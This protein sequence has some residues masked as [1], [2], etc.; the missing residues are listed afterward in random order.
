VSIPSQ[1]LYGYPIDRYECTPSQLSFVF[2]ALV[3]GEALTFA[4][5]LTSPSSSQDSLQA[6]ENPAAIAGTVYSRS[7]N[8]SFY[9]QKQ[10]SAI[11]DGSLEIEIPI[12]GGSL[13]ASL[14]SIDAASSNKGSQ[15]ASFPI[16]PTTSVAAINGEYPLVVLVAGAGRTDRDG[17]NV[18]VPGLT[19]CLVQLAQKLK[20]QKVA[21]LRYDKRGTGAAYKLEQP[22]YMTS[23]SVH[24]ADLRAVIRYAVSIQQGGRLIVAGM[25]EGAWMASAALEDSS[26]ASKVDGLIVIDAS[27]Q[28]PMETLKASIESLEMPMREKALEAA[29]ALVT[30]GEL[31]E[32]P[33]LLADFFAPNKKDWLATW[34]AFDPVASIKKVKVPI[35]LVYGAQDLQVSRPEFAKLVEARPEA[36][37]RVVPHMNYVLKVVTN[38]EENYA[39]FTDPSYE[40]SPLLVSLIAAF[41]KVTPAP[42]GLLSW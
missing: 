18:D 13:P 7:V 3:P 10:E 17:N 5:S 25:N 21:T 40:V 14:L 31:I 12:E 42:P 16:S 15:G 9:V 1:G 32:V 11:A 27:G 39:S 30:R 4:G 33:P 35:L 28:S 38:E 37:V 24:V 23:F 2:D 20:L 6:K 29:R 26:L 19:N 34:L 36:A 22:G 8:G 41:A